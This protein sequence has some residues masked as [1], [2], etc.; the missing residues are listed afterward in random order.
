MVSRKRQNEN[1]SER[2]LEKTKE[3]GIENSKEVERETREKDIFDHHF[4]RLRPYGAGGRTRNGGAEVRNEE[5]MLHP[6]H[7]AQ[8]PRKTSM[9]FTPVLFLL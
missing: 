1:I 3:P 2:G 6:G 7:L 5:V 9:S 8:R 4:D